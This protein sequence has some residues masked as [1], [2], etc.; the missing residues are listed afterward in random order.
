MNKIPTL[1]CGPTGTGKSKYIQ[2]VLLTRLPK[3]QF[4][5]IEIGFSA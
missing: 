5:T 3:E 2:D 4:E 1:F